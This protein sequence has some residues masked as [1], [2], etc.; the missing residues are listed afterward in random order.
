MWGGENM[1]KLIITAAITGAETTREM[2]P[3]LPV[4]PAEQARDAA[5]CVAAGA[6]IIH[7]HV[8]GKDGRPS[9]AIGDFRAS[10]EAIRASCSPQPIIQI[11]TGG[12]IGE[13]MEKRIEP[14]V[15]LKP[16][17]ASLN[18]N[19]MNF[20][21]DVFLNHPK[22]VEKLAG[23]ILDLGVIPEV[24]VY[25]AGDVEL[26]QRLQ[27]K[28]LLKTP[29]HYQFVL[30]VPGGLSGEGYNLTHMMRL[31]SSG[32]SWAVAGIGRYETPV[33]VMAVALGG[34]VRVGFEDNV[35]YHKGVLAKSNAELVER[36]ARISK[37]IGRPVA[38]PSEAREMLGIRH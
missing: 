16:E 38:T 30:G 17:M 36:I 7:L 19:S 1:Q 28:G 31:I 24:E 5:A 9:Q 12:A 33:A 22:D 14:I 11:S 23:R 32:D 3:A 6:T 35:Y 20:G 34:F 18:I 29:I 27:K 8:R 13:P 37:E 15:L 2:N 21:D 26:A 4:T 10:I 25:D